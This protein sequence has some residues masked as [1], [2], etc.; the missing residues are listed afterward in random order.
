MAIVATIA[1][2]S[3]PEAE[4]TPGL[5]I[6]GPV[7]QKFISVDD[8]KVSWIFMEAII[9]IPNLELAAVTQK[10]KETFFV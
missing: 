9:I 4:L 7:L 3:N 10:R 8:L 1:E 2:T 6:L 5:N